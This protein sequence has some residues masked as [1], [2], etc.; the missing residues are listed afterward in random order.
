M[1]LPQ[2]QWSNL[3]DMGELFT[4][5]FNKLHYN[6]KKT[7]Q[8]C[9][10]NL[11]DILCNTQN[12]VSHFQCKYYLSWYWDS[13]Y[14]DKVVVT[15]SHPYKGNSYT[16]ASLYSDNIFIFKQPSGHIHNIQQGMCPEC[17]KIQEWCFGKQAFI[18]RGSLA[19]NSLS[20][21]I[22]LYNQTKTFNQISKTHIFIKFVNK[23]KFVNK[24]WIFHSILKCYLYHFQCYMKNA[25]LNFNFFNRKV[26]RPL[27]GMMIF[28]T[29]TVT[30]LFCGQRDPR[31]SS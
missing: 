2:C 4:W 15:P 7:Q 9:V 14:K 8:N 28:N 13:H 23:S 1:W 26:S 3:K 22:S 27:C 29:P 25:N 16:D 31:L 20:N 5:I 24:I 10:H 11:K 19:W 6:Q 18:V 12:A 17:L 30:R 21:Q